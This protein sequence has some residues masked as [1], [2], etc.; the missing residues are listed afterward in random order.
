MWPQFP[1][2]AAAATAYEKYL[3]DAFATPY[4]LGYF[5]CQ[6]LDHVLPTGMLKQGLHQADGK[7]YEEFPGL[8]KALHQRLI[9]QLE[10]EG[11]L[12]R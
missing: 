9:E 4:I 10:K 7:T 1:T 5:K 6:Y 11:R 3:R 2:Q 12:A 8:L